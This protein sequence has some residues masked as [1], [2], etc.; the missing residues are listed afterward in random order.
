VPGLAGIQASAR[1]GD[2]AALERAYQAVL[3]EQVG[4]LHRAPR[5]A[6]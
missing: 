5:I 6:T 2:L 3:A 4:P 1:P